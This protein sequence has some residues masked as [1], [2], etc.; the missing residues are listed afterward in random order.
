MS[1]IWSCCG[2]QLFTGPVKNSQGLMWSLQ[3]GVFSSAACASVPNSKSYSSHGERKKK[4]STQPHIPQH[5]SYSHSY[6]DPVLTAMCS[7]HKIFYF[8]PEA[9]WPFVDT[10]VNVH[11]S[12]WILKQVLYQIPAMTTLQGVV[13]A[14]NQY[15]KWCTLRWGRAE[16]GKI[17]LMISRFILCWGKSCRVEMFHSWL[18]SS[19]ESFF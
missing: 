11:W 6:N 17:Q 7:V 12:K 9:K 16:N 4:A 5:N 1:K 8:F 10:L 15:T 13:S 19:F 3:G 18:V 2:T 14:S